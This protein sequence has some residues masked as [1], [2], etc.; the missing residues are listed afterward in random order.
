MRTLYE[1]IEP[2][3]HPAV[4]NRPL[5]FLTRTELMKSIIEMASGANGTPGWEAARPP[6][7]VA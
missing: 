3:P 2:R 4:G 7:G 6:L 5:G 1:S